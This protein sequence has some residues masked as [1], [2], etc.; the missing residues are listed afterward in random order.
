MLYLSLKLVA[1][2]LDATLLRDDKSYDM[3]RF[4]YLVDE[5]TKQDVTFM[6]A[7]GN[8]NVKI[9]SYVSESIINKVYIAGC[10]GNDVEQAGE[11]IHTN[12]FSREALLQISEIVDADDDYQMLLNT[13]NGTYSKYIY[14]KDQDYISIYYKHI[15]MIESYSELPESEEAIKA[16]VLSAKSLSDTKKL[17]DTIINEVEGVTAVTSGGG[18]LDAYHEDGGKGSAV[19]WLQK[20]KGI[21]AA[22]TMAF[23]DSLNDSSMMPFADYSI[24]MQNG[25]DEFKD[26]CNYE[27]GTNEEQSVIATLEAFMKTGN[28]DFMEQYKR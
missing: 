23:G 17:I 1:I 24:T 16:A 15:N 26:F 14:D 7:S 27:I 12:Y 21:T 8:D 9:K 25:D 2:D 5:L 6:I 11:H 20:T 10:N 3:E 4:D 19:E 13:P 18:W 28:L 22:E